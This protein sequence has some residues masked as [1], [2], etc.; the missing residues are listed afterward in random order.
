MGHVAQAK[1]VRLPRLGEIGLVSRAIETFPLDLKY[2][3]FPHTSTLCLIS[4]LQ[5][6]GQVGTTEI[7][8]N[9]ISEST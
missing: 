1:P 9:P 8:S 4:I 7:R 5:T 6:L 3:L 2:L